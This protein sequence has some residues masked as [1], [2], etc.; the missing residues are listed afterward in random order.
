MGVIQEGW[1]SK[2]LRRYQDEDREGPLDLASR[3]MFM[4]RPS[5]MD[6]VNRSPGEAIAEGLGL[7]E[8]EPARAVLP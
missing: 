4:A 1:S 6:L 2:M 5:V 8:Q 7:K 3:R